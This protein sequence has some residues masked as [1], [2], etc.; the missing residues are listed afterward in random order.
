[1]NISGLGLGL[2]IAKEIVEGHA[3]KI[4]LESTPGKGS[5]FIVDLPLDDKLKNSNHFDKQSQRNKE[6]EN[7]RTPLDP[8]MGD[9]L[10]SSHSGPD[11]PA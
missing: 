2:F 1:M 8:Q 11:L 5:T 4:R 6:N 7:P 3:G 10:M 9:L